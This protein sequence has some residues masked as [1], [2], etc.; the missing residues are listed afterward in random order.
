VLRENVI[1]AYLSPGERAALD[2]ARPRTPIF[3][4][5]SARQLHDQL[6]LRVPRGI[7]IELHPEASREISIVIDAIH[8][9][10]EQ[11]PLLVRFRATEPMVRQVLRCHALVD[12]LRLSLCRYDGILRS[13]ERLSLPAEHDEA[14]RIILAQMECAIPARSLDLGA[15]AA[16]IGEQRASVQQFAATCRISVRR[17]EEK[18]AESQLPSAKRLL[19]WTLTLHTLWRMSRLEFSSKRAALEAGFSSV[20]ALSRRIERTIGARSMRTAS[21]AFPHAL[22]RFTRILRSRTGAADDPEAPLH[23]GASGARAF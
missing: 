15:C 21:G 22:D 16:I 20:E 2:A 11:V 8:A 23:A 17:L 13:V 12:D 1:V 5:S 18:L 10:P 6:Q 19:M 14:R 3:H 9:F 4:C 7:V